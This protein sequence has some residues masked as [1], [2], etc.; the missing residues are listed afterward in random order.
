MFQCGIKS[1]IPD[2]K[3]LLTKNISKFEILMRGDFVFLK[4]T[5]RK[6]RKRTIAIKKTNKCTVR[7]QVGFCEF[8]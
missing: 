3:C 5:C 8:K 7:Y 4:L 6:E 2:K 1:S